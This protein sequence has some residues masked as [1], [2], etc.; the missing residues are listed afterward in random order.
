[1][2]YVR[3]GLVG[4]V[5]GAVLVA[6]AWVYRE[7]KLTERE[8]AWQA[9]LDSAVVVGDSLR[10]MVLH[11]GDSAVTAAQEIARTATRAAQQSHAA[12]AHWEVV[13]DTLA[14]ALAAAVEDTAL[15]RRALAL[16]QAGGA[17]L[18]Q[19]NDS[20]RAAVDTVAAQAARLH[21]QDSTRLAMMLRAYN[22]LRDAVQDPHPPVHDG[23]VKVAL[24]AQAMVYPQQR[25]GVGFSVPLK[26]WRVF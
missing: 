11:G 22:L 9:R 15:T 16:A 13:A 7:G 26:S 25:V 17:R 1:M 24:S 19:V 18:V 4:M 23:G 12:A 14:A 21:A 8:A 2:N 10:T 20:L 5:I 3:I 6:L